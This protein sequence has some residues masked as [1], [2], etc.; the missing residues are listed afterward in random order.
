MTL[1]FV[2][3]ALAAN[4]GAMFGYWQGSYAAGAWMFTLLAF[5][6]LLYMTMS[7]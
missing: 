3:L 4:G 7:N 5:V 6:L 2:L 1:F